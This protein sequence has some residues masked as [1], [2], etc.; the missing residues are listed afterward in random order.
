MGKRRPARVDPP[1]LPD[2]LV[3]AH[4]DHTVDLHGFTEAVAV[5]RVNDLL[6][7]WIRKEPGAVLHIITGK[8]NRS[9][10]G[11][12]LIHAVEGFLRQEMAAGRGRRI[13]DLT[14]GPGGGGWLVRVAG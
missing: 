8:G 2:T 7:T 14:L 3:G 11:P 5:Q 13:T 9:A 6:T 4:P 10:E 12:V 1:E